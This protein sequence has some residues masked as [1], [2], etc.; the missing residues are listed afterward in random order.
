MYSFQSNLGVYHTHTGL[1]IFFCEL[2]ALVTVIGRGRCLTVKYGLCSLFFW[3]SFMVQ[4]LTVIVLI[5]FEGTRSNQKAPFRST[6]SYH[7]DG[8]FSYIVSTIQN[9]MSIVSYDI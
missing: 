4:L 8:Y 6:F 7:P 3:V 5:Q 9:P 2:L 1:Q